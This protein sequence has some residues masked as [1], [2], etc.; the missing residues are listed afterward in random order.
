MNETS[1]KIEKILDQLAAMAYLHSI[2]GHMLLLVEDV[3]IEEFEEVS[4]HIGQIYPRV[5]Y[6]FEIATGLNVKLIM[7]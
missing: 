3:N 1:I 2:K 7:D 5:K 6:N 4:D